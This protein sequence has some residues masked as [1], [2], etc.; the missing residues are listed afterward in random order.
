MRIKRVITALLGFPIVALI[1]IFGNNHV[2]NIAF[3]IVAILS[4][5]EYFYAF[6]KKYNPIRWI[7]IS[8]M[9]NYCTYAH[10]TTRKYISNNTEW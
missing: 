4:I 3:S 5:K 1:L 6:S 8:S 7:R 2:V 9:L 10:C